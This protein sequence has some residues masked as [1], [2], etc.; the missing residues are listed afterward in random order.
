MLP[1]VNKYESSSKRINTEKE[2]AIG[3]VKLDPCAKRLM[4]N[5]IERCGILTDRCIECKIPII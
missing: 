2:N 1:L 4:E 5:S 3:N